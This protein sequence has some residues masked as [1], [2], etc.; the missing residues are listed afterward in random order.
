M[1]NALIPL[2]IV[3][4]LSA[5][6]ECSAFGEPLLTRKP[7]APPVTFREGE[8]QFD[9]S[10][11]IGIGH[12]P[13]HA[14]PFRRDAYG[15]GIGAN[16]YFNPVFGLGIDATWL[17]GDQNQSKGPGTVDLGIF[18]GSVLM[19]IPLEDAQLAPYAF[20]GGGVTAG[21]GSW[22]HA[23]CGLGLEYRIKPEHVGIFGDGRW[24]YYGSRFSQGD[25]NNFQFRAG[26]RLIF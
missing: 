14:G 18:S 6:P 4:L 24:N 25:Q 8:V 5:V 1:K 16:Y 15:V 2:S 23:H 26:I 19:R 21:D 10:P 9:L 13:S 3:T 22:G 20:V 12:G 11:S 7:V 17:N